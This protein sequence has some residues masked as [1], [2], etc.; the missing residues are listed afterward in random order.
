MRKRK[1]LKK[2]IIFVVRIDILRIFAENSQIWNIMIVEFTVGNFLSFKDK[3]TI[4]FEARGGVSELKDN[5]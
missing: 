2:I 4:N 5:F 3:R 1:K